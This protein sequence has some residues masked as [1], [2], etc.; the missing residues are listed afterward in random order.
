MNF[1]QKVRN[2]LGEFW[3]YSAMLFVAMRF[4]DVVNAFIGLYLVPKYVD[5][6][7]LGAVLPLLQVSSFLGVP[8]TIAVSIFNRYLPRF[9]AEGEDGRVKSMILAFIPSIAGL[10]AVSSL[11]AVFLLPHVFERLRVASGS[12]GILMFATGV[13]TTTAPVF[14]NALQGLKKFNA[15]S[16]LHAA[17]APLRLAVMVVA[18]PFRALSGYMLGQASTPLF[19]IAASC[20]A[21]RKSVS[22]K[23]ETVPFWRGRGREFVRFSLLIAAW[24]LSTNLASVV[25]TVI[26]RQRL[27][28]AESAAYYMISRFAELAAYAGMAATFIMVPLA[29]EA[30]AKG[31]RSIGL[32]W[33]SWLTT[34]ATGGTCTVLL[35]VFGGWLFS[36]LP[37]WRPYA[38]YVPEM[39]LLSAYLTVF[40]ATTNFCNYESAE[41]RFGFLWYT[42]PLNL[43]QC[44]F[45]VCFTGYRF[46]DGILPA[47][48]VD[49]MASLDVANLR[50]LICSLLVFASVQM[51]IHFIR[52]AARIS[53]AKN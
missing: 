31:K 25:Q 47:G 30:S 24:V 2:R 53:S 35:A 39:A 20:F 21:L 14:I 9:K 34:F 7:E 49:W 46:F 27:S 33:K 12:L 22:K 10:V 26:I 11:I 29:V 44:A 38:G 8:I 23:I 4:G 48:A 43:A 41:N 28:E 32:L 52:A 19:Q 37:M 17:A 3:W 1:L 15:I 36:I 40:I 50:N 42:V 18:M 45:L 51:V 16:L 13:L 6:A 5:Q